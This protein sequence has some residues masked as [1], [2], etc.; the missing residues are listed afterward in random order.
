M[1]WNLVEVNLEDIGAKLICVH[2]Q[3]EFTRKD[4][5]DTHIKNQICLKPK[6]TMK[7]VKK[8]AESASVDLATMQNELV[9]LEK[10]YAQL[11][12]VQVAKK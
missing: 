11:I 6:P 2:C 9:E 4:S 5:L 10:Q 12:A 1:P 7:E 3:K 8:L